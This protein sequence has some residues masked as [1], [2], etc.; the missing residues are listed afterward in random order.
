MYDFDYQ[1][2]VTLRDLEMALGNSP[3]A[4]VMAGGQTLIPTLKHRLADPSDIIDLGAIEEIKGIR[5]EGDSIVI[6]AM[7]THCEVAESELVMARI[8]ALATLAGGIGDPQ[9]RHRGTI[10]GSVAN[11]D[12]AADYPAGCLGLGATIH[13]NSRAILADDFFVDTFETALQEG[14]IIT[15]VSFPVP[16]RAAYIKFA[17]PASRYAT[18]GVLIA[19]TASGVRVAVTGAAPSVFR[20]SAIETA[21]NSDFSIGSISES[22][23]EEADLNSDSHASAEYRK[24]LIAVMARRAVAAASK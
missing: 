1:C 4:V 6:G 21:L 20:D 2:P 18:V 12:P 5:E 7:T 24:H 16:G 23:A 13:T 14:E 10:G 3:D 15:E 11:N 22:G 9:V 17:N 8:P 19:K